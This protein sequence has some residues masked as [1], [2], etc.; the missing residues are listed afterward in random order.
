MNT[1]FRITK[2]KPVFLNFWATWCHWCVTEMDDIQ[3]L[4]DEYKEAGDDSVVILGIAL[5]ITAAR[6]PRGNHG[7]S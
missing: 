4:Y 6:F 7:V 5:R 1:R 3:M 2:E